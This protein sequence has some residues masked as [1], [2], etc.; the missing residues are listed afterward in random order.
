MFIN[1]PRLNDKY[2]WED[3]EENNES[4]KK[5][6]QM[7]RVLSRLF[8]LLVYTIFTIVLLMWFF[9]I[10]IMFTPQ[11]TWDKLKKEGRLLDYI[12]LGE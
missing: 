1:N 2:E 3:N 6:K 10:I 12:I 11:S 9:G 8:T 4:D 7:N 5:D